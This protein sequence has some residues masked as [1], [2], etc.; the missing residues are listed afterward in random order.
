MT[1]GIIDV[2]V[3]TAVRSADP[4]RAVKEAL[5]FEK[6]K[7]VVEG[8]SFEVRGRVYALAIGKAACGMTRA[9]LEVVPDDVLGDVLVVTKYGYAGDCEGIKARVIEAGHPVPDENSLLA[10][11][12]GL[13]LAEKVGKDDLLLTLVSG[14]GS[15]LFVYPAEGISLEDLIRTNELLLRSGATIREINTVRK[16]ISRVKGGRLARAVKG[17]VVSLI[18]SDVVGDDVSSI[19]SGITAPDPTTYRRRLRGSREARNLG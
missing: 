14:G 5:H 11:R 18:V 13:E 9:A 8:R 19:A 4:Y 17:T 3:K 1:R 2:L 12:L 7:L 15:A 10:G 6:G 16:H